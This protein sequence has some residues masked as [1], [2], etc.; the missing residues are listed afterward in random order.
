MT[1]QLSLKVVLIVTLVIIMTAV[2]YGFWRVSRPHETGP[3]VL[4]PTV[5]RTA[6]TVK[7][8][9]GNMSEPE[10]KEIQPTASK[11][12]V[13]Q[14]QATED[15]KTDI[16]TSDWKTYRNAEY[17]FEVKIP[18]IWPNF[19][20]R[21]RS[22][23][24]GSVLIEFGFLTNDP[25][26]YTTD[27]Y[28]YLYGIQVFTKDQYKDYYKPNGGKPV[29]LAQNHEYVFTITQGQEVPADLIKQMNERYRIYTTF[30]LVQ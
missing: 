2:V 22:L 9:L 24:D 3:V 15:A 26:W 14:T 11:T 6:T 29:V 12:A 5:S 21:R 30:K 23:Y 25:R 7:Q 17:G 4:P 20:V 13:K 18:N 1:K 28:A 10:N 8:D 27:G 16:D 19:N